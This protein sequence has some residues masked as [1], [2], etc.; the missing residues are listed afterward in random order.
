MSWV[1]LILRHASRSTGCNTTKTPRAH[2][3]SS[4]LP[5]P[6]GQM[7]PDNGYPTLPRQLNKSTPNQPGHEQTAVAAADGKKQS[8]STSRAADNSSESASTQR[9]S[10]HHHHSCSQGLLICLSQG[11][12]LK[13][14]WQHPRLREMGLSGPPCCCCWLWSTL[15]YRMSSAGQAHGSV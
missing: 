9:G 8:L 15:W 4:L 11:W 12:A 13:P 3:Q 2:H 10:F 1:L 7:C 14:Q 6:R 5:Q